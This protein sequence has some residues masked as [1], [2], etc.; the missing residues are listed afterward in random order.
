LFKKKFQS[1]NDLVSDLSNSWKGLSHNS[2]ISQAN[3]FSS[4]YLN[5]ISNQIDYYSKACK[6]YDDYKEI[7]RKLKILKSSFDNATSDSKKSEISSDISNCEKE[8]KSLSK[9]ISDNLNSVIK[10]KLEATPLSGCLFGVKDWTNDDNFNYYSQRHKPGSNKTW[11]N[12]FYSFGGYNNMAASGC[13][14]TSMA[15]VASSFGYDVTPE[16]TAKWSTENGYHVSG[17]TV[18]DFFPKYANEI[19]ISCDVI[20][21]RNSKGIADSLSDGKLMILDVESGDFTSSLHFIVARGYDP[22]TN[23]VL[24]AD[25]NH[26]DRCG[27]W[28]LDRVA[29]QTIGSW[30]FSSNK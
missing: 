7:D 20:G 13:G 4:K 28:D 16:D 6:F 14:P 24:I 15:M 27:W 11:D 9:K 10:N 23:K 17:G 8:L 12:Y 3:D 18:V 2:F 5:S 19:G 26:E 21:G 1:Y 22:K 30:A 25:P 29:R